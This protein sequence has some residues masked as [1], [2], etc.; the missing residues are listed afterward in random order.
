MGTQKAMG[1]D[2]YSKLRCVESILILHTQFKDAISR[3]Q[4]AFEHARNGAEPRHTFLTGESGTGKTLLAQYFRSLYPPDPSQSDTEIR[5]LFVSTPSSPTLKGL[6]EAILSA[7]GDHY[8]QK[9]TA[10]EKL[11]RAIWLLHKRRIQFIFFDEFHHFIDHAKYNTLAA[12][13]DWLKR[14]ID[15]SRIPCVLMGL[16]RCRAILDANEQ[17]RRRF[18]RRIELTA[19][20]MDTPDQERE[21]RSVLHQIDKA[22]PTQGISGLGE[23]DFAAKL[24]FASD[25]LMGYLRKLI[26]EAFQLMVAENQVRLTNDMF[27][28]AFTDAI[29]NEGV[30]A[31]NPFNRAF[32]PRRLNRIGEPF[33]IVVNPNMH[34]GRRAGG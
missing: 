14:F 27:E 6:G 16:P 25:G 32:I 30:G 31:S 22:L 29:W 21:F 15:D 9:G 34:R 5:V 33:A 7:L 17:L 28:R 18:S 23:E 3:L 20:S 8:G 13:T 26:T 1:D 19:F 24:Y 10:F 2:F 12:V 11:E 4:Q